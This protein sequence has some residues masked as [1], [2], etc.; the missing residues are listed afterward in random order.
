MIGN[1]LDEAKELINGERMKNYGEPGENVNDI[2]Q[3]WSTYLHF[4]ISGRDVCNMMILVKI[5]RDSFVPMHDNQVDIAG[6]AGIADS[7]FGER[8]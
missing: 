7:C 1:C 3:F 4:D 6:Y 2:A 5:S 8:K